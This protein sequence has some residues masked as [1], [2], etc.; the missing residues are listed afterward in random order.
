MYDLNIPIAVTGP[1]SQPI[2]EDGGDLGIMQLP[3]GMDTFSVPDLPERE[4][5][6]GLQTGLDVLERIH[7]RLL[8]WSDKQ[9]DT[10][11]DLGDLDSAN[12]DLVAQVLGEGEVSIRCD[13]D[14]QVQV[15]ESVLAGV[16]RIRVSSRNGRIRGESVEVGPIPRMIGPTCGAGARTAVAAER[17]PADVQNAAPL[18]AEINDKVAQYRPGRA[19]HV[20]NLTLLPQTEADLAFLVESLG[21]GPVTILSR[22]YGNCRITSTTVRDLWWVQYFNSQDANILNTLEIGGVPQVACAAPEDI[23]DSAER[24]G[25]ILAIYR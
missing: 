3:Q 21:T 15:Q 17:I 13:G 6:V 19:A 4:D 2:E 20:I 23:A 5:V 10:G 9:I 14:H 7:Q 8:R 1:G 18:I 22:G 25:E 11:L 24:L 12:L 16:W